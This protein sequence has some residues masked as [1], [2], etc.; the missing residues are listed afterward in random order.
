MKGALLALAASLLALASAAS[1]AVGQ[2]AVQVGSQTVENAFP[3]GLRFR[4][5]ASSDIPIE[6]VLL[7]YRLLPRGVQAAAGVDVEPGTQVDA[8]FELG[9]PRTYLAPGTVVEYRWELR[10]ASGGS[11]S[12]ATQTA[13]YT[14]PRFPFR[15][16]QEGGVTLYWYSGSEDQA[17]RLLRAAADALARMEALLRVEVDFPVKVYVYADPEDMA[18]ALVPRSEA[19]DRAVITA[20]EKVSDDTVLM[21]GNGALDT[22]RHE[23]AHIVTAVAG[24]GPFSGLPAWLDEGTAVYAQESPGGFRL[25]FQE[26]V[27]RD[28][29]LPLSSIGSYPGDPA[30]V[31]LFYGQSWALVSYLIETYGEERF[32]QLFATFKKGATVDG[33][34]RSVYGLGLYDLE[35]RWRESLGLQPVPRPDRESQGIPTPLPPSAIPLPRGHGGAGPLP[36]AVVGGAAALGVGGVLLLWRRL[37]RG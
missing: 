3:R 31:N 4:L 7:H 13:T 5:T 27:R 34:L 33:A 37:V 36:W 20:G 15:A 11:F 9:W 14:D 12:T 18:P 22:L 21:A 26:A 25:A 23:L 30:K 2:P 6:R 19:F 35:D 32:A 29:L 17:R 16:L 24:E 10:D 28:A 1:V 8:T